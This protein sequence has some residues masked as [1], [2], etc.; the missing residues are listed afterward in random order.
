[1]H[2]QQVHKTEPDKSVTCPTHYPL[3]LISS[4]V[5]KHSSRTRRLRNR[6]LRYG[7]CTDERSS[8]MA[9]KEGSRSRCRRTCPCRRVTSETTE[10]LQGCYQRGGFGRVAGDA[11][12][13]DEWQGKGGWSSDA[14]NG[15]YA[16]AFVPAGG[17]APLHAS[18]RGTAVSSL[19]SGILVSMLNLPFLQFH[20]TWNV[21]CRVR[22]HQGSSC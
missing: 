12:G 10:D 9:C 6:N 19:H 20:A 13:L 5:G 8:R 3:N 16:A 18:D 4:Q 14:S 7:R 1:M 21:T 17:N 22:H 2:C 15:R 11:Q